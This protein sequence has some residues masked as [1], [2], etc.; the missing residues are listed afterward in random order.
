MDQLIDAI[1]ADMAVDRDLA[2]L[3][4]LEALGENMTR[5]E[6]ERVEDFL[7]NYFFDD[8]P[9]GTKKGRTGDPCEFWG[10]ALSSMFKDELAAI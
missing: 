4:A 1:M 6:R 2:R 10:D 5:A 3:V 7:Y 8:M 9:Y